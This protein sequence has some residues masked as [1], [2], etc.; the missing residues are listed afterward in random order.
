MA[1]EGDRAPDFELSDSDGNTVT[2]SDLK[3]QQ[4]VL[5]F[6]PK[7]DTPGCTTEAL[8]FTALSEKFA[9]TGTIVLG[10]SPDSPSSH[11][12]FRD[13]HGLTVRLISDPEQ[14][15]ANAYGVWVEKN[16]YGRKFMGIE[17]STFL[18]NKNGKIARIWRKVKVKEHAAEVL[19]AA[20][21]LAQ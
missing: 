9:N 8:D 19:A 3:G 11:C 2:L 13:K 21:E 20:Q 5:Y 1:Q 15:A 17:R 12:K 6:Y 10:I 7:D 16:M 4:V 18:I 14:T